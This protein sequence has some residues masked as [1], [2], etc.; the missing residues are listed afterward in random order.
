M[1]LVIASSKKV[2]SQI[3]VLSTSIPQ[4]S[5]G[6]QRNELCNIRFCSLKQLI[7]EMIHQILIKEMLCISFGD[8]GKT[9]V[10]HH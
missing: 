9:F 1:S 10:T 3:K 6:D 4:R 5:G 7:E 2:L 8:N